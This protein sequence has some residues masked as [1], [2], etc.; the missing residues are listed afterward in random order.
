MSCYMVIEI[1]VTDQAMYSEY[2]QKV[3]DIVTH[4]GGRYLARGGTI[5][6]V[7]KNWNP[8]RIIIIEFQNREH[9]QQCFHSPEY[10]DIAP[11]REQSTTSKAVIVEGCER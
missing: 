9:M 11:M 5:T 8:E 2:V 1:K 3:H 10:L 4:Y 6:P 7:S